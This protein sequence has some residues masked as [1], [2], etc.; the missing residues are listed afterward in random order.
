MPTQTP[1][2]QQMMEQVD[3]LESIESLVDLLKFIREDR[4]NM[5]VRNPQIQRVVKKS[6]QLLKAG[7]RPLSD[8]DPSSSEKQMSAIP[9]QPSTDKKAPQ[10]PSKQ[11]SMVTAQL[12][13]TTSPQ[14]RCITDTSNLLGSPVGVLDL[15]AINQMSSNEP[16]HCKNQHHGQSSTNAK[17][18]GATQL[19][20]D[21][22]PSMDTVKLLGRGDT[23]ARV[24]AFDSY[25]P[26]KTSEHAQQQ[27]D[28]QLFTLRNQKIEGDESNFF[29]QT[30]SPPNHMFSQEESSR[31]PNHVFSR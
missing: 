27:I 26:H 12:E 1:S 14:Q 29:S 8:F 5:L 16:S 31:R 25:D 15:S 13:N 20:G 4:R 10:L 24:A 17:G 22:P 28:G 23:H 18:Q 2:Q 7:P 21:Q 30:G 19:M 9:L 6:F 3:E 11:S